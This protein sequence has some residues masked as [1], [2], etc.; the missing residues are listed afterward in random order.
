MSTKKQLVEYYNKFIDKRKK[1]DV[2]FSLPQLD[3]SDLFSN[4]TDSFC[5][6]EDEICFTD[7]SFLFAHLPN[8]NPEDCATHNQS[9]R[10][11][12]FAISVIEK[13]TYYCILN[14][15]MRN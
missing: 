8:K 6:M 7:T 9:T 12:I 3:T 14:S 4:T 11:L 10:K 1:S 2:L 15:D 5:W 13:P